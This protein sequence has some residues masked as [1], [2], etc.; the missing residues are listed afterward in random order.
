[1]KT[2]NQVFMEDQKKHRNNSKLSYIDCIIR[3]TDEHRP[4]E[5]MSDD[6]LDSIYAVAFGRWAFHLPRQGYIDAL[7]KEREKRIYE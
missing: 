2:I 3:L 7:R 4:F 1:M 6:D 5:D